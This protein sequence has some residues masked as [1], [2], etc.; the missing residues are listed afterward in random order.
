MAKS[1]VRFV[2]VEAPK[3]F[4]TKIWDVTTLDRAGLLGQVKWYSQWRKYTF[5]AAN[6]T[7]FDFDC[8]NEIAAFVQSSTAEHG[9]TA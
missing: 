4:K 3:N 5:F 2:E 9:T 1:F 7:L 8:L 6:N